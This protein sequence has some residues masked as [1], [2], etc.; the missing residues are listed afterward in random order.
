MI[1]II[2]LCKERLHYYEFVKPI[3]D[4]VKDNYLLVDYH[5]L[6][7][8]NR[9][10]VDKIIICGTSL[11]D[12]HYLKHMHRFEFL[13]DIDKPVLGICAGMHILCLLHGC[14]LANGNAVGLKKVEFKNFLGMDGDMEVY[15]LHNKIVKDD[16]A[17]HKNFQICSKDKYVQ[18][19]K[20]KTLP[21]YGTM[22]H[23]EVRNKDLI[24]NFLG[25][26]V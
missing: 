13:K 10:R 7:E 22:F 11:Q 12:F 16:A 24:R 1:L 14:E 26:K 4:I 15:E 19:V 21:H 25:M 23:P 18:A 5:E 2:N 6:N 3:L 8:K 9:N 20:H 17:L